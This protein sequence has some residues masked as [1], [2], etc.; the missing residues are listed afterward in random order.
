MPTNA[1]LGP[2]TRYLKPLSHA[3]ERSFVSSR[4]EVVDHFVHL[5]SETRPLAMLK[6]GR[7]PRIVVS[8]NSSETNVV[9]NLN[10][11]DQANRFRVELNSLLIYALIRNSEPVSTQ[12]S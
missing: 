4:G 7:R 9:L 2:R 10:P 11:M 12:K 3:S 6:K 5:N 1:W 8:W